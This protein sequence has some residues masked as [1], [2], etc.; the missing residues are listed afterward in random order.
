MMR[1]NA[2]GR[3]RFALRPLVA[4]L[5]LAGILVAAHDVRAQEGTSAPSLG[6][7]ADNDGVLPDNPLTAATL[8]KLMM[9]EIASQRGSADASYATELKL[10][11]ETRDPRIARRATEFAV[12]ARQPASAV[13]AARLWTELSP[14]SRVAA[15][16]FLTLARAVGPLR[17]KPSRCSPP[18]SRAPRRSRR[19][20][21]R[22]T[23]CSRRARTVRRPTR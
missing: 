3:G 7:A 21:P 5:M 23:A 10:A 20:W 16:T 1:S 13:E 18:R 8:F 19:R 2:D 12:Q 9:S 22:S 6:V 17:R 4:T 11:R 14:E 15:D